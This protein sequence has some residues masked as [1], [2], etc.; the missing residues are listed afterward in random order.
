MLLTTTPVS[1]FWPLELHWS[2]GHSGWGEVVDMVL[3]QSIQ[4]V[5]IALVAFVY[6]TVLRF[7]RGDI[8]EFRLLFL[9]N[10]KRAK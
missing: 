7:F 10:R 3:F 2:S 5:V 6:L 4:D 1:L 9:L 8:L